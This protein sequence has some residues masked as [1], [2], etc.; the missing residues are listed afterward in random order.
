MYFG[1]E[2]LLCETLIMHG[3]TK[4]KCPPSFAEIHC[5][6]DKVYHKQEVRFLLYIIGKIVT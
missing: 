1:L 6:R 5:S 2:V 3:S 4:F